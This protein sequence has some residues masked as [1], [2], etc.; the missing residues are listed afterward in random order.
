M[1]ERLPRWVSSFSLPH[2]SDEKLLD[3]LMGCKAAKLQSIRGDSCVQVYLKE[4]V[5]R[6][7]DSL[8]PPK[9]EAAGRQLAAGIA[10]AA[11]AVRLLPEV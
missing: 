1:A 6:I 2:D 10:G 7:V 11:T 3:R 9:T 4:P 5:S 8:R